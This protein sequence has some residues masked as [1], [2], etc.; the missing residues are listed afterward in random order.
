M[1]CKNNAITPEQVAV[2]PKTMLRNVLKI[3]EEDGVNES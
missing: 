2:Y 1:G 3:Q